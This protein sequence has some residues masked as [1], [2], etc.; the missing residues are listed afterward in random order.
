MTHPRHRLACEASLHKGAPV[1]L[2]EA[3][4]HY[5]SHVL[6]L[7]AGATVR[8]FNRQDGEWLAEITRIDKRELV[9]NVG[10]CLRAPHAAPFHLT[11]CFAPIKGGRLEAMVE[12]A[13]ELGVQALQPVITQRTIVDKVNLVRLDAVAREAAEQ[14]ERIDWPE[15]RPPVRLPS[16]LGSWPQDVPL[17]VGDESG[18]GGSAVTLVSQTHAPSSPTTEKRWGVLTGPEGG[19]APEELQALRHHTAVR[20]VGLGPRILR[21]D[22]ALMALT[23]ATLLAWGD[24]HHPPRFTQGTH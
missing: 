15:I 17:I 22:T 19:F 1:V 11:A 4:A 6:R 13:T 23:V 21:A 8:L 16:L 12:K 3:P 9:L 18:D 10:D 7:R 2:R 14:C 20:G 24:W 5:L